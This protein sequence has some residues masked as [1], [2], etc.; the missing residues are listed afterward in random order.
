[1]AKNEKT[2]TGASRPDWAWIGLLVAFIILMGTNAYTFKLLSDQMERNRNQAQQVPTSFDSTL[3]DFQVINA[4]DHLFSRSYLEKYLQAAKETG[5][6]KT[7]LVASSEYTL[8][9][10]GHDQAKGNHENTLEILAAAAEHPSQLIAFGAIHP[11]DP[12]KLER[13]KFYVAQGARGLKLYTGHGNFYQHPLDWDGMEEIYAYCDETRL[14]ICWHVNITKYLAEFERVMRKHPNM[15]VIVPHFGVTFFQPRQQ[16]FR[17]FQRLLDTYPNL[18]TDTSFGTR[19][20]LVSGL[21]AVSGD[22]ETFRAFFEKYS[23]RILFGTDM[24]I[25]GNKEKTPE[26]IEAVLRACRDVLEKESFHFHMGAKGSPYA[27]KKANNIY[28]AYRGLNLSDEILH[29]IYETNINK[30]LPPQP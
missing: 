1:M 16:P 26:W 24:V 7:I 10:A 21:E 29:K 19:Q 5:I 13:L 4:H 28:G 25:T 9:G 12:E 17:E 11:D 14:P 2:K 22:I 6:T 27:S 23:D 18:Y 3:R 20:I 30:I 15:I 8:M